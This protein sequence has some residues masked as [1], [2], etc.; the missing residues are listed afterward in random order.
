MG[1]RNLGFQ[2]GQVVANR[3]QQGCVMMVYGL[4]PQKANTDKLFNLVCLYGNVA[5]VRFISTF[6]NNL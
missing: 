3:P 6:W 2:G 4:D 5:R 1:D